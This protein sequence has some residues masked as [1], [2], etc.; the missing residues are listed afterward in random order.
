MLYGASIARSDSTNAKS[1]LIINVILG[2]KIKSHARRNKANDSK[3]FSGCVAFRSCLYF[4][5]YSLVKLNLGV[6]LS[7]GAKRRH[8]FK[9]STR[10]T[11]IGGFFNGFRWSKKVI[12][13]FSNMTDF[14]L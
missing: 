2:L 6:C 4:P 9:T 1:K 3:R 10:P 14:V 5:K 11:A 7:G 13:I 8:L 12:G